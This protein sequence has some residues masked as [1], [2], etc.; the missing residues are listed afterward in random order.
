MNLETLQTPAFITII[1]A[2]TSLIVMPVVAMA[3][4]KDLLQVTAKN[5]DTPEGSVCDLPPILDLEGKGTELPDSE[6]PLLDKRA[7]KMFKTATFA[8]G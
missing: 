2:L 4:S 6:P 1:L 7:A 8:M 5:S 3:G